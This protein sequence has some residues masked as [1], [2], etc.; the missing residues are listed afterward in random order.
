MDRRTFFR[1]SSIATASAAFSLAA[2]PAVAT[3]PPMDDGHYPP[4]TQQVEEAA[5]AQLEAALEVVASVPE[6]VIEQGDEAVRVYLAARLPQAT[7]IQSPAL[8]TSVGG[9]WDKAWQVSKC[10]S[11]ITLLIAGVGIPISMV[12]KIKKL[13]KAVGGVRVLARQIVDVA[14][15]RG[16]MTRRIKEVF[17]AFGTGVVGLATTVLGIDAVQEECF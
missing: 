1:A 7:A 11:A 17:G 6:S 10:L 5:V 13:A 14:R 16:P 9:F 12:L 3:M 2:W 15:R 8:A 4:T